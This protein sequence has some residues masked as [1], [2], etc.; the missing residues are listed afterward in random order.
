MSTEKK[1]TDRRSSEP[2]EGDGNRRAFVSI[3]TP[4]FNE[5]ENLPEL[6]RRL[7]NVLDGMGADWEWIVTDD[8]STDNTFEVLAG[9]HRE[10][11][12]I[13]VFRFSRNF[14]SHAAI[15]CG[16]QHARGDCAVVAAAD[17][18]DPPEEIPRLVEEWRKGSQIVWAVR[19]KREGEK[20]AVHGF[21]RLYYAV[22]RRTGAL[23]DMPPTG[24]DFFLMDSR[25]IKEFKKFQ[26]ANMSV[27]A[28]IMWMG[29]RQSFVAYEKQS[30]LRGRSGW[31]FKKKV[32]LAIDS[33]TSFTYFPIRL[34]SYTGF[35]TAF[36][37]FIYAIIV[38]LNAM[39]GSPVQ[40]WP[41]LMSVVLVLGGIQMTM[42]GILGEYLWRALDETRR[43]PRYII[44]DALERDSPGID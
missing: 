12:R 33:I 4:A 6:H 27:M 40:G 13:R 32:K 42:L 31:S 15:T 34:M 41:S 9:L 21:S 38:V 17:L 36:L 26:E 44:E 30:R 8:H 39:K 29:F 18:Q 19:S 37:G 10:D 24:A 7:R 25:V 23:A 14:G 11:A 3:V 5:A 16:L 2:S 28:L 35:I 43:R 22:L 20:P 1:E